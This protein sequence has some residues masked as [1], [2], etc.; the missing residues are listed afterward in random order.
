MK[1]SLYHRRLERCWHCATWTFFLQ[2][3]HSTN[4]V[5]LCTL[6]SS[7][8]S[9]RYASTIV[10]GH[11]CKPNLYIFAFLEKALS[12]ALMIMIMF[13]NYLVNFYAERST[14]FHSIGFIKRSSQREVQNQMQYIKD[15]L[16]CKYFCL[17]RKNFGSSKVNF[18]TCLTDTIFQH[19]S[20]IVRQYIAIL[21]LYDKHVW[22]IPNFN[23]KSQLI[24]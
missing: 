15:Y 8:P 9:N 23:S 7:F 12:S 17:R 2:N 6:I 10:N 5:P 1:L 16:L 21:F 20:P 4:N 13:L 19:I 18:F 3:C 11:C 22:S 24:P 14:V